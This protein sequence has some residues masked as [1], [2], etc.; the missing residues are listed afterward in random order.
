MTKCFSRNQ[1]STIFTAFFEFAVVITISHSFRLVSACIW[2]PQYMKN[3]EIEAIKANEHFEEKLLPKGEENSKNPSELT[4]SE[5]RESAEEDAKKPEPSVE[6]ESADEKLE[7][8]AKV[9]EESVSESSSD[10]EEPEIE[11]DT[12][13]EPKKDK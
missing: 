9:N 1:S 11:E 2:F 4:E 13:E 5:K 3:L 6:P 8:E 7:D 12:V 10:E